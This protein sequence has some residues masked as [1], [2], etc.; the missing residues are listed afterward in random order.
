MKLM[1]TLML[2]LALFGTAVAAAED[3]PAADLQ[4]LLSEYETFS[5]DFEQVILANQGR[6]TEVTTGTLAVA[7]PNRF[8]WHAREP[9]PQEIVSDGTHVWI[10]DPDLEQVTRRPLAENSAN[11]P[12][13]ILGGKV[14][15][16]KAAYLIRSLQQG[17]ADDRLFELTPRSE[18]ETF[19]RIR[20]YFAA[21]V[22]S[23]LMLEDSL[24][25][26]TTIIFSGQQINPQFSAGM[27]RFELPQGADLIV[28]PGV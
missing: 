9:F 12:A 7:K 15:Q 6:R 1:R 20:L 11:A 17:G 18:Q 19:Q 27:F 21:G 24:G 13:M 22:L 25:Q 3:D 5:A 10:Y 2:V 16:L 28:D 4:R 23:E 14:E 8:R 26:R